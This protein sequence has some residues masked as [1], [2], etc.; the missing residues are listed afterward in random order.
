[1]VTDVTTVQ[2]RSGKPL[3]MHWIRMESNQDLAGSLEIYTLDLSMIIR[4]FICL[5]CV[6]FVSL[7]ICLCAR[8]FLSFSLSFLLSFLLLCFFLCFFCLFMC[9]FDFVCLLLLVLVLML[10]P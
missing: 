2:S 10:V 7:F 9:L 1:M 5:L 6:C 8:F 3:A 4:W